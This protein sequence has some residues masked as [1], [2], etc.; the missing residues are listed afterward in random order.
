MIGDLVYGIDLPDGRS[1]DTTN[2]G[3]LNDALALVKLG[4]AVRFNFMRVTV[5]GWNSAAAAN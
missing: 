3:N 5:A 2:V 4:D 1:L